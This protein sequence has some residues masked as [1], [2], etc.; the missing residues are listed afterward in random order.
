MVVPAPPGSRGRG[1]VRGSKGRSR[2]S[3]AWP[4]RPDAPRASRCSSSCA[5]SWARSR[6]VVSGCLLRNVAQLEG[7]G[8]EVVELLAEL[9][10]VVRSGSTSSAWTSGRGGMRRHP[11]GGRCP[12]SRRRR[13]R[14]PPPG[15]RARRPAPG[16][17]REPARRA[18]PAASAAY[19][20]ARSLRP[21][22]GACGLARGSRA[23][24]EAARSRCRRGRRARAARAPRHGRRRAPPPSD[25]SRGG[26]ASASS[27]RPTWKSW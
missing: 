7:I 26:P 13:T 23:A 24:S 19:R 20:P 18:G 8:L 2:A 4:R 25:P 6:R 21:G 5:S 10:A 1:A 27:R 17:L 3:A 9:L 12:G 11:A 15:R 14:R 16:S 22:V